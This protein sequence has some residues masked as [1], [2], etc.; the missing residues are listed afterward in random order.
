M[1]RFRAWIRSFFGFSRRETNACLT[2][3]PLMMVLIFSEPVYRYW[4]V[5]QPQNFS[6]EKRELDSL[7]ATWKWEEPDSI[8]TATVD[9]TSSFN[10]NQ[11]TQ[12]DLIR[13]GFNKSLA[14]RLVNYRVKGGKFM[15][16]K[17]LLKIYGMDSVLYQKLYALI[18][19]PEK[20]RKEV[21]VENISTKKKHNFEP[22]DLNQADTTQLKQIY[23][24]GSKLSLRI[25]S[26][27]EKLGGFVKPAQLKEVYGLDSVVVRELL[28]QSFVAE[29]FQPKKND[30]NTA[31]EKTLAAHPYIKYKLAKAITAYR[32]QHGRFQSLDELQ[33]ITIIDELKFQQIKPYLSLNP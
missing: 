26:Y 33:K 21:K 3:L 4:F 1:N 25:V 13:L 7:M 23:G 28:N 14:N 22:F 10:P 31:T 8:Q 18:S 29:N 27:R 16:K 6:R 9:A 17:D 32:F 19:L 15:I 24:I 2:L 20:I 5:R 12:E 30:I 11:V